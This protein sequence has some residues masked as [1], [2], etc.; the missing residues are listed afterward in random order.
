MSKEKWDKSFSDEEYVYG[1]VENEFLNEMSDRIPPQSK[2]ACFAEGEGRNAVFLAQQGH[3]VTAYD[4]STVGLEKT[5]LLAERNNVQVKTVEKDLIEEK[6][7]SNQYDAAVMI[8]GHVPKQDQSFFIKNM[9]DSVKQGGTI[10]FEVYSEAQ[11]AYGTGG[12]RSLEL[13]YDPKDMLNWIKEYSCIHFY[14]G[15]AKRNEGNRHVGIGHVI[16]VV[17]KKGK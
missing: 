5:Q 12:P 15:E 14:Y 17:L 13:L 9:I 3:H 4:Q 16:Q 7:E 11:L 10:I 8:Y 2:V 6:V 1:V